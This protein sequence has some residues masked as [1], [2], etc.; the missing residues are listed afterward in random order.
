MENF[1]P[2]KSDKLDKE[3]KK[4]SMIDQI[5][6]NGKQI[7]LIGTAHVSR[8]S[9]ELVKDTILEQISDTGCVEL[10][11]TRLASLKDADR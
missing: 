5:D 8:Q 6:C 1:L 3:D 9:A 4:N 11:E 10:C 7:L 2:D